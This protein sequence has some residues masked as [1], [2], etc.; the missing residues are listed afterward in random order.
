MARSR[1]EVDADPSSDVTAVRPNI[2]KVADFRSERWPLSNRNGGPASNRNPGRLHV[3]T[4]GRIES[5]SAL[6]PGISEKARYADLVILGQYE[7]QG[8][9]ETHPLP[10]AHSVDLRCGRPVLV[11]PAV[12]QPTT[13]GHKLIKGIPLA[14]EM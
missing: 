14:G 5:E 7:S 2:G 12:V 4:S 9:P 10:I 13:L 1:G 3:G 11:V 6:V 8:S